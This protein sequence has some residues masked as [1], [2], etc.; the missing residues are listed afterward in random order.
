[1][2]FGIDTETALSLVA[3]LVVAGALIGVLAGLFGVGGGAISVPVYFEIFGALGYPDEVRMP[4][5]VGTSLAMIIPTSISSA[6]GHHLRGALDMDLLRRW[7]LPIV[8]GVALGTTIAR[9][10]PPAVFQGVFAVV[11][12]VISTRLLL[13]AKNWR[14]SDAL[15]QGW[16]LRAYGAVI[17][18]LATLM[19][20]G[21]GAISTMAMTLHGVAIHRAVATSAGVGVVISIPGAVGYM[22]AGWGKPGLPPDALGFVSVLG[23]LLT[24]PTSLTFARLGVRLAHALSRRMLEVLFGSFLALVS[25]RFLWMML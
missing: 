7:T 15:P 12:A 23:V 11:A 13:G 14:I 21:G 8:L 18:V 4:L 9:V 24:V 6:R 3:A 1:M 16:L 17:G 25:L 2:I 5:A 10:A 19:G 22:L 20:V